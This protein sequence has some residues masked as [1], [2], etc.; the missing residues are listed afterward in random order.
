MLNHKQ[1]QASQPK[2]CVKKEFSTTENATA[3]GV[4]RNTHVSS[5]S[6]TAA[7]AGTAKTIS[8]ERE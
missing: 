3:P 2:G 1:T 6:E 5:D 4:Q 7:S 8:L